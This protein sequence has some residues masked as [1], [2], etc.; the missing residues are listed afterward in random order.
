MLG[1]MKKKMIK[2]KKKKKKNERPAKP[3]PHLS[4]YPLVKICMN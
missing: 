2:K 1:L 3:I 4:E